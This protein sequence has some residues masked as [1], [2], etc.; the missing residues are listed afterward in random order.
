MAMSLASVERTRKTKLWESKV[1]GIGEGPFCV[2]EGCSLRR[3]PVEGLGFPS[4]GSV[5]KS[6]GGGYVRQESMVVVDHADKPLQGLH[7]GG[8]RKSTNL[9]NLLLQGEDALG[10]DTMAQEVDLFGPEYTFVVAEDKAGGAETFKNQVKVTP[11][12]FRIGGEDED[13]IDVGDTE[14]EI[15]E[16]GVNHLLKGGTSVAKAKTGVVE[17]LGVKGCGDGGLR[18]VVGMHGDLVVALQ[19]V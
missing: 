6:H 14:G 3:A 10:R 12:L 9:S 17:G 16:D 7:S 18:D 4:E 5:Q 1:G 13:V 2:V 11:V 15:A 8:C 19:D